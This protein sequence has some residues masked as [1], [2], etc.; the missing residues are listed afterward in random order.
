MVLGRVSYSGQFESR[1]SSSFPQPISFVLGFHW[2]INSLSWF[3]RRICCSFLTWMRSK[4]EFCVVSDLVN[5]TIE[6][7]FTL[8]KCEFWM[9]EDS[10]SSTSIL[11]VGLDCLIDKSPTWSNSMFSRGYSPKSTPLLF[12]ESPWTIRWFDQNQWNPS[13]LEKWQSYARIL[14][15]PGYGG[16]RSPCPE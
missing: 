2:K 10:E 16:Q 9:E 3:W 12:S 14:N 13:R 7:E 1:M 5:Q 15:C 4:N 8:W 6:P 11:N